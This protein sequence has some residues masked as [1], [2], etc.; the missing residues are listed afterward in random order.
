MPVGISSQK[1]NQNLQ[2]ILS[3]PGQIA[4][5]Q[6]SVFDQDSQIENFSE[7]VGSGATF[8]SQNLFN[9]ILEV[10]ELATKNSATTLSQTF[11]KESQ[12]KLCG[13]SIV[14]IT[15]KRLPLKKL[16]NKKSINNAIMLNYCLGGNPTVLTK[17]YSACKSGRYLFDCCY[18]KTIC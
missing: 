13:D 15:K 12:A 3:I 5:N 8:T 18:T 14:Q 16:I 1:D 10:M 7:I 9:I 17:D 4:N 11:E 2:D 6:K